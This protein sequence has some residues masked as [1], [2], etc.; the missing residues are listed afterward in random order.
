MATYTLNG[1]GTMNLSLGVTRLYVSVLAFP[2]GI[3]VGTATPPNYFHV[4]MLRWGTHG[5]WYPARPIDAQVMVVDLGEDAQTFGW[6][7]AGATSL[8]V[9]EAFGHPPV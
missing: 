8:Q 6:S 5:A 3:S 4:G 7:L 1:A 2:P 9:V